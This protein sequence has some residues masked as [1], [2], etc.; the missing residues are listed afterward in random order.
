MVRSVRWR[1]SPRHFVQGSVMRY[2]SP[3]QVGH[4]PELTNCPKTLRCT[5]RTSPAPPHVSHGTGPPGAAD[6]LPEHVSHGSR[7]LT[8]SLFF[9]PV[10]TSC[11]VSG[12][13]MRMS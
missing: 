13:R 10:A 1:P 7:M 3:P 2:P 9:T 12:R 8:R 11:S 5:R 6:P 4:G